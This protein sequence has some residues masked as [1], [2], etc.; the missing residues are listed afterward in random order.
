MANRV[1]M[2]H[3]LTRALDDGLRRLA[4]IQQHSPEATRAHALHTA[5]EP[6]AEALRSEPAF[7]HHPRRMIN[8][9]IGTHRHRAGRSQPGSGN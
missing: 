6:I 8:L 2:R 5:A 9:G 1:A 3:Q 4:D 7:S